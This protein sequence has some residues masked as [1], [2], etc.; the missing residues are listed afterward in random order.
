MKHQTKKAFTL[1]EL[2]VVIAI[3]GILAA[4]LLPALAAAKKK[5][6]KINCVNNLKQIGL[7]FRMFANDNNGQYPQAM[8]S[9]LGGSLGLA[10]KGFATFNCISNEL[11]TPKVIYCPSDSITGHA[12]LTTS[13]PAAAVNCSYFIGVNAVESDPQMILSGDINLSTGTAAVTA[14]LLG[15]ATVAQTK[16]YTT[17]Y[18]WSSADLHQRYGN[19]G[20]SDGSVQST[21]I[22]TL[23]QAIIN[24]TNTVAQPAFNF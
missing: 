19:L 18:S 9:A 6:Q 7:A 24:G 15:T 13:F 21:T 2:L 14:N 3:I 4:M 23:Q 1:I 22:S 17:A 12:Q 11:S 20:L 8:T 10:T 16:I 5:A